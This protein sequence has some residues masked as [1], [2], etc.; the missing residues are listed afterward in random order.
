[1]QQQQNFL[2]S[3]CLNKDAIR[4]SIK[5][6][7]THSFLFDTVPG[8]MA[9]RISE[10]CTSPYDLDWDFPRNDTYQHTHHPFP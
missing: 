10:I 1:M 9:H 3:K 4:H 6:D 7:L 2:H 5:E 8:D